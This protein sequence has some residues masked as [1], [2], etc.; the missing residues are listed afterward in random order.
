MIKDCALEGETVCWKESL[1]NDLINI[2][3]RYSGLEREL[4]LHNQL[5]EESKQ[6]YNDLETKFH[7]LKEERDSLSKMASESSQKLLLVNDQKENVL[8]DLNT[9]CQRRKD[10]EE[11]IKQFSIAFAHRKTSLSSFHSEFRSKIEKLRAE[12]PVSTP[13]FIG[14]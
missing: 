8:K 6:R 11:K 12:N 14:C 9:E 3:E 1:S 10:L 13:K 4:D 7:H 2:K 5:L